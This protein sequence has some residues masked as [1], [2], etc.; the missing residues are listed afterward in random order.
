MKKRAAL[1]DI[2]SASLEAGV[3][4]MACGRENDKT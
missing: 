2:Q 4:R 1:A 3:E